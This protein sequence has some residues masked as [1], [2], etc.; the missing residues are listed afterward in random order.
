MKP[1][2]RVKIE[3]DEKDVYI[4]NDVRVGIESSIPEGVGAR[5]GDPRVISTK[6]I[7]EVPVRKINNITPL[8]RPSHK[9]FSKT[10]TDNI[11]LAKAPVI[12]LSWA[13]KRIALNWLNL[14]VSLIKPLNNLKTL[15]KNK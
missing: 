6:D 4:K 10:P 7:N 15:F 5:M 14:K 13:K 12:L 3:K 9:E 8:K 2:K 11:S 1:V